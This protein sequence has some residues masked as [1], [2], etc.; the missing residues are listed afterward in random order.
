MAHFSTRSKRVNLARLN[1]AKLASS[2]H[3]L[4]FLNSFGAK[5][6]LVKRLSL[7][8]QWS[9]FTGIFALWIIEALIQ[10]QRFPKCFSLSKISVFIL[11]LD[12]SSNKCKLG[13]FSLTC[14]S[15]DSPVEMLEDSSRRLCTMFNTLSELF[16]WN[17][18]NLPVYTVS[19]TR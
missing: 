18:S 8:Q 16:L 5:D 1:H 4:S 7:G 14:E 13:D 17:Y 9:R 10:N 3:M 12:E 15:Q 11:Q 2:I 6:S 19:F